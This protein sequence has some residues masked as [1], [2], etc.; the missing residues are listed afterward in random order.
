MFNLL[1]PIDSLDR[2]RLHVNYP[3]EVQIGSTINNRCSHSIVLTSN[4]C[5]ACEL[6]IIKGCYPNLDVNCP[7]AC[8][9]SSSSLELLRTRRHLMWYDKW[10]SFVRF[11]RSHCISSIRVD[12]PWTKWVAIHRSN[13]NEILTFE[14]KWRAI[15]ER[16]PRSLSGESVKIIFSLLSSFIPDRVAA[17]RR[18]I[19][20]QCG[21]RRRRN[22]EISG[23]SPS[24]SL[25]IMMMI[26][27]LSMNGHDRL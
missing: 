8:S 21:S 5:P 9:I 20:H 1:I 23:V 16:A 26:R 18:R 22:M 11:F 10:P 15:S 24:W 14:L 13:D 25:M 7:I 4:V 3:F 19:Y 6:I 27:A 2:F 12:P 17:N